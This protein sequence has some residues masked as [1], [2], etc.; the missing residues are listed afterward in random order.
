M[1]NL[2][3]NKLAI[4][5]TFALGLT[6]CGGS[7][8]G[9]N[10][11]NSGVTQPSPPVQPTTPVTPTTPNTSASDLAKAKDLINT[12]KTFVT[13]SKAVSN[14]YE[15]ASDILNHTQGQRVD[16]VLNIPSTLQKWMQE[17]GATSLTAQK[18]K[19]ISKKP[20]GSVFRDNIY[21]DLDH[22]SLEP[23]NDFSARLD[24]QG[25]LILTGTIS[26]KKDKVTY[27]WNHQINEWS[28][29]VVGSDIFNIVYK[30]LTAKLANTTASRS[31]TGT[32][33]F[34][35]VI[36]GSDADEFKLKAQAKL[37][38]NFNKNVAVDKDFDLTDE[39][40]K[41]LRLQ[42]AVATFSNVTLTTKKDTIAVNNMEISA[43]DIENTIQGKK[44]AKTI[45]Y[46]L[47]LTGKLTRTEPKTDLD[48]TLN[49]VAKDSAVKDALTVKLDDDGYY[50][51]T[52][53]E[54]KA[55]KYLPATALLSIKGSVA[56][57]NNASNAVTIPLNFQANLDRTSRTDIN[58]KNLTATVNGK[59]LNVVGS[60]T[61]NNDYDT[62]KQTFTFSQQSGASLTI[63]VNEDGELVKTGNKI[64]DITVNGKDYGDLLD[65][66]GKVTAKFSDNTTIAL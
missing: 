15:N 4:A 42:Q 21:S 45:P 20:D 30:N 17:N 61:L 32:Y 47:K 57:T 48:L 38:A 60:T 14:V 1:K 7:G 9:S 18:V 44:V 52:Y 37:T 43:L 36:V 66:N 50:S 59:T 10:S 34:D 62:I 23:S 40:E 13:D 26:V 54:E 16:M 51:D 65:N 5:C 63:H 8:D 46:S 12:A 24:N 27:E 2:S 56:K 35:E 53:V 41:G 3:L 58:L 29:K 19:E 33:G 28:T 6:A 49:L 64:A 39:Q 55:G 11:N 22:A 31:Y 25:N